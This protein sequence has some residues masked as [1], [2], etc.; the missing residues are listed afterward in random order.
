MANIKW[1]SEDGLKVVWA[2]VKALVAQEIAK[3][4]KLTN[5]A[6]AITKGEGGN[7]TSEVQYT[8][9]KAVVDYVD[10]KIDT[11][12]PASADASDDKVLSTKAVAT[13]LENLE[14]NAE[15]VDATGSDTDN[16][17]VGATVA[18]KSSK[19]EDGSTVT[20]T[21]D[22]SK[23]ATKIEEIEQAIEDVEAAD[24]YVTVENQAILSTSL[25]SGELN[26]TSDKD[27]GSA[28]LTV[29][30]TLASSTETPTAIATSESVA[31]AIS[32]MQVKAN[33]VD[34]ITTGEGGNSTSTEKYT[35]VKSVVDYVNDR[36]SAG[37]SYKVVD[38]LPAVAEAEEGVIYL[39]PAASSKD[40][41]VKD[42]YMLIGSA[43]EKIGT[44]QTD[45]DNY[46]LLSNKVSAETADASLTDANYYNAKTVNAIAAKK[47]NTADYLT[48]D[49]INAICDL[50][51]E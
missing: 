47:V 44:T 33:I 15:K 6:T 9:V 16:T 10:G 5:K 3:C 36:L 4:E 17:Y 48:E 22:E 21:V 50:T 49:E 26:I 40:G 20:V 19:E 13:A 12:I 34:A 14:S 2:K 28:T 41:N 38:A 29:N 42:E 37:V 7:A 8:S 35:S 51:V 24:K 30:A 31:E 25:I 18:V 1:L 39:V 46:E 32:D 11:T 45:L 23:L 27:G 43:F